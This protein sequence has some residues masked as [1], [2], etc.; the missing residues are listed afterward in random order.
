MIGLSH[1]S[2]RGTVAQAIEIQKERY[3]GYGEIRQNGDATVVGALPGFGLEGAQ[4]A[5]VERL[6][7]GETLS[8]RGIHKILKVARTIADLGATPEI[9]LEHLQEAWD[10]R[11]QSL[12]QQA[13][14]F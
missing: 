11:C 3:A 2:I 10:L 13:F 14:G 12:S 5:W 6:A 1:E 8:Y 4:K 9:R 7:D